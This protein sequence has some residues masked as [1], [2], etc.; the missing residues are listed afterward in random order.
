MRKVFFPFAI[1]FFLISVPRKDFL[2][3]L[4]LNWVGCSALRRNKKQQKYG[5]W[6]NCAQAHPQLQPQV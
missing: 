2:H 3:G 1:F 6:Q 5:D 4:V